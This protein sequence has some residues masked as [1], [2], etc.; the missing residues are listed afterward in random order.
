VDRVR[1]YLSSVSITP[2]GGVILF[3]LVVAVGVFLLGPTKAQMPALIV[4]VIVM[5]G[6][7]G[8]VPFGHWGAGAWR[9]PSLD[10]RRQEFNPRTEYVS[11]DPLSAS[12]E[13]EMWAKE[14]ERRARDQRS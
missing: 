9:N 8:G 5:I 11:E 1:R 12:A 13:A 7:V 3:V 6:V 4:A 10:Q 2:L 14:R